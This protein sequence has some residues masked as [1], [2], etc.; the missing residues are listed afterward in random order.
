MQDADG[1]QLPESHRLVIEEDKLLLTDYFFHLMRQLRLV[2][3]SEE[4]RK[5]RGGKREKV[6]VGYGGLQCVH[7][8]DQ[9]NSRKFFWSNVDRLANSFAEIPGH[10]LKCRHC[11]KPIKNSLLKLKES[12]ADQM[13]RLPRGSQKVFFRRMWRR[14]HNEDPDLDR[15]GEYQSISPKSSGTEPSL[16]PM[17]RTPSTINSPATAGSD[18]SILLLERPTIEAAKV[19][20]E[21]SAHPGPLSPSSR[22]LL[23][24]PEDKEWLSDTDCFIRRQIEVFCATSDDILMARKDRKYPIKEQQVGIRCIHC[25]LSKEGA[26]G[27]AV[28]YPFSINGIY[29][30]TR[31]IQRIHLDECQ[32]LPIGAKA[33]LEQLKGA[34]S[35]S[36]VLRKYYVLAAKALG[37]QDTNDGIFVGGETVPLG[38]QAAFAFSGSPESDEASKD[39]SQYSE[40]KRSP[41][42]VEDSPIKKTRSG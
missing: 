9:T 4:D 21:T 7:C 15:K 16:L 5:T 36:S 25:A 33:K 30:S 6:K 41:E 37:L 20:S 31:E 19:L 24:I 11:P 38:P 14:I 1:N 28:A 42:R 34:A 29:E 10:V 2:R 17:Y 27:H 8:A 39:A 12:H 26:S 40:R 3:F 32:N 13:S 35:L 18:E 22:V 23:S